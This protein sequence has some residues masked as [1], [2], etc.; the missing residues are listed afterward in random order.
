MVSLKVDWNVLKPIM[1]K[2]N[3][4][5]N[6]NVES[7]K[8]PDKRFRHKNDVR[9]ANSANKGSRLVRGIKQVMGGII[10]ILKWY[11]QIKYELKHFNKV[12]KSNL[13]S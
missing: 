6:I 11:K 12:L 8:D 2:C 10:I 4:Q 7:P 9:V 3:E 13:N 5:F 1:A